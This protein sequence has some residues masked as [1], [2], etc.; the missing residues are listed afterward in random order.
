MGIEHAKVLL[1]DR[2]DHV[3]IS[4]ALAQKAAQVWHYVPI[5]GRQPR[6]KEDMIGSGLDGVEKIDDFEEYK[7]KADLIVFPGEFEGEICDR[8]WKEG[9]RAFGSGMSA[10][11]EINRILFLDTL[12]KVGLPVIKTYRAE[13]LDDAYE[14]LKNKTNKWIKLPYCRG[15]FD[16]EHFQNMIT[17]EPWFNFQRTKLGAGGAAK[18]ELLIQD[19]YP[20]VVEGGG[21]RYIVKGKRTTKGTIGYEF[22]DKWYIYKVVDAFP[23]IID[24]IDKKM[25]PEFERLGYRGAY[26]TEC[27]INESGSVRFTDLTARFGAPPGEGLCESYETFAQDV[28]DVANGDMPEMKEKKPYGAIIILDSAWNDDQEVCVDFPKEIQ[29]NV[30]LSHSY[31][32]KGHY[33]CVPNDCSGFFGAV[34]AQGKTMKEAIDKCNEYA[35]QIICLGLEHTKIS[36]DKAARMIKDG[37]K[38]GIEM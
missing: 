28:Y 22:K 2:G 23:K 4:E 5:L 8:M 10:E 29:K 26:S 17:F 34:T 6:M 12:K 30:K 18:I 20:A 25:E 15:E 37:K 16:T 11:L 35:D 24:D 36:Y 33:Y 7:D 14:Y 21:D 9:R 32:H 27:R 1:F 38:Y 19:D 13:G 3:Y 31:K